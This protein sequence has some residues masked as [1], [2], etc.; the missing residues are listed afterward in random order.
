M[1]SNQREDQALQIEQLEKGRSHQLQLTSK[2]KEDSAILL[3]LSSV[4]SNVALIKILQ[5]LDQ[6]S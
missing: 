3:P 5:D 1:H 4:S 2:E 6:F